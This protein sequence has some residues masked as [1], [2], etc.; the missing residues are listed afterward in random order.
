MKLHHALPLLLST[1]TVL[2]FASQEGSSRARGRSWT[3]QQETEKTKT[4]ETDQGARDF[5]GA[6]R[7]TSV[8]VFG[9]RKDSAETR[10]P[11]ELL[12][13]GWQLKSLKLRKGPASNVGVTGLL[14]ISEHFL[15]LELHGS[16][17]P[18]SRTN[19]LAFHMSMG[20]EYVLTP[21][22][23]LTLQ[24]AIGSFQDSESDGLAW[25]RT[26]QPR[27][28]KAVFTER[29]L[30][31]SWG[32]NANQLIFNRRAPQMSGRSDIFGRKIEPT[33]G[34]GSLSTDIFGRSIPGDSA[35]GLGGAGA[36]DIFGRRIPGSGDEKSGSTLGGNRSENGRQ[37]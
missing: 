32:G 8:D 26:G 36:T 19:G 31:L 24:T 28:F 12:A 9:R 22:G 23:R 15:S 37:R 34:E 10:S 2:S 16:G 17:D 6:T 21:D 13:G 30:L 4:T 14:V 20:G 1:L 33:G 7:E 11:Q 29:E 3:A 25:E 35:A 27:D 18:T 5:P